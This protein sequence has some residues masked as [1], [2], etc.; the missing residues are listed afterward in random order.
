MVPIA[1]LICLLTTVVAPEVLKKYKYTHSFATNYVHLYWEQKSPE[2]RETAPLPWRVA[3][4]MVKEV[5]Q[6]DM[7]WQ[8]QLEPSPV[9]GF[10]REDRVVLLIIEQLEVRGDPNWSSRCPTLAVY[11]RESSLIFL[12]ETFLELPVLP[13]RLSEVQSAKKGNKQ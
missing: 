9:S 13:V 1:T 8:S 6:G 4:E 3:L 5:Q 10:S 2:T 7:S 12:L 11:L